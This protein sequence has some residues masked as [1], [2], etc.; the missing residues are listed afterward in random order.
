MQVEWWGGGEGLGQPQ[1]SRSCLCSQGGQQP[2]STQ[3]QPPCLILSDYLVIQTSSQQRNK[4]DCISPLSKGKQR[5]LWS[6]WLRNV[7]ATEYKTHDKKVE[8]RT[9]ILSVKRVKMGGRKKQRGK[10]KGNKQKVHFCH[11]ASRKRPLFCCGQ[12]VQ[13]ESTINLNI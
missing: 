8:V 10:Q 1:L 3:Q 2:L 12:C 5:P 7:I 11:S 6:S 13:V 4:T 9:V